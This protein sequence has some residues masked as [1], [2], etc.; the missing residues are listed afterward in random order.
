M[1]LFRTS[2]INIVYEC[3]LMFNFKIPSEQLAQRR[4]NYFMHSFHGVCDDV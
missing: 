4:G 2:V 1:K 3:Q